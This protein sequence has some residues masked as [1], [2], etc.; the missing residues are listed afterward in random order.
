M[1]IKKA[2]RQY[3][4]NHFLGYLTISQLKE[5]AK[6]REILVYGDKA[7]ILQCISLSENMNKLFRLNR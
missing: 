2:K 6:E 4:K 3:I 1:N 7:Q 5:I